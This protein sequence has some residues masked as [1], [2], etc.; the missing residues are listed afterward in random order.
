MNHDTLAEQGAL[1][2]QRRKRCILTWANVRS[3]RSNEQPDVI[4]WA[5]DGTSYVLEAKTTRADFLADLKKPWRQGQAALGMY[6]YYY[7]LPGLLNPEALPPGWGLLEQGAKR[8]RTVKDASPCEVSRR[9]ELILLLQAAQK[10]QAGLKG[11]LY[12]AALA[13]AS[14]PTSEPNA[15]TPA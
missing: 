14:A 13:L 9:G 7:T 4:G 6:R 2:L 15:S 10:M 8:V 12:L 11:G 5:S 3:L 1:Y